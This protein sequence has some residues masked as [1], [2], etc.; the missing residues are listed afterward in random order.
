[1]ADLPDSNQGGLDFPS[2]ETP[3]VQDSSPVKEEG[4]SVVPP[5][6][7][8]TR[9]AEDS[10]PPQGERPVVAESS[11]EPL[12]GTPSTPDATIKPAPITFET[13]P[14]FAPDGETAPLSTD[15]S[16]PPVA[17]T[18][19][20]QPTP[21]TAETP[22]P[23]PPTGTQPPTGGAPTA[24]PASDATTFHVK[25]SSLL[26]KILPFFIILLLVGGIGWL[27]FS[28]RSRLPSLSKPKEVSLTYWGLWEPEGVVK[29]VL[30]DWAKEQPNIKVNYQQQ[31]PKEYRERLQSALARG[32][33]PDIFRFHNT[34]VPMLKTELAP[35]SSTVMDATTFEN[36]FYPVASSSL[37]SGTSY[38]GLPLEVDT[39]ALFYNQDFLT[40]AGATPPTT[41]DELRQLAA[42]LTLRD[43]SGRIQRAGVALGTTDNVRHWSDILALMMLQN[44]ANLNNPTGSLAEDALTFYTIFSKTDRVWDETLPSSLVAFATGK[45]AMFFGYSWDVFEIKNIN[46]DLN[47]K[48]VPAP[49]LPQANVT[50]ASFWVEGVAQ[51]SA[52]KEA[53]W[54]FLQFLSSEETLEKLYQVASQTRL[55]GEPYSRVAMADRLQTEPLVASFL[56]Q[57]P[58]AQS[59]YLCSLTHD[60]GINDRMI[61]YFEDAVNAVN[62][63]QEAQQVLSTAADG[64]SQVLSQY[65]LGSYTV[66]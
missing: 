1:M 57:A 22:T 23:T 48:I 54:Q 58:K 6:A 8:E 34:W 28:F 7:G 61:K 62:A 14:P 20:V 59:W 31:S 17:E 37:R 11:P 29:E 66:R 32:E 53:A 45:T 19:P 25:E 43:A 35:V 30:A 44:G 50:W 27:I 65:D 52:Q 55:F 33:G 38:L 42:D 49:Q 16:T 51:K 10:M 2:E 47:F 41:W 15:L 9:E 24:P 60:N 4:D 21:P 5:V 56:S 39:L 64:V 12:F 3:P 36:T 26:K 63:G 40:A 18:P 13:T 46:P